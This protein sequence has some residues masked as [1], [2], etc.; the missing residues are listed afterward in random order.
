MNVTD[1]IKQ[2]VTAALVREG[3]EK[4]VAMMG[5]NR[6]TEHYY[7]SVSA[8][9]KGKKFDECLMIAKSWA[10]KYQPKREKKR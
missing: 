3:Y 9:I 2:H 1:F 6:A 7:R 4:S 5:A 10:E 8:G